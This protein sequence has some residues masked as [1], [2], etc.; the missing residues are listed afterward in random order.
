MK[1]KEK[2]ETEMATPASYLKLPYGRVVV[3]DDDGTF[4]AEIVEFPGCIATGDS[5]A[6]A[7]TNLENVAESWLQSILARGQKVPEPMDAGGFSGKLVVRLPRSLHRRAAYMAA[8]D[9]V[10]LNQ[11]IVSSI[12]QGVGGGF[13]RP[14]LASFLFTSTQT[15]FSATDVHQ[16]ITVGGSPVLLANATSLTTH[17]SSPGSTRTEL[18]LK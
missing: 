6:E 9:G 17:V 13:S 4:R 10:S 18:C 16:H 11:F 8:R 14:D 15:V 1:T 5:A 2:K 7:L 12:A 3:P